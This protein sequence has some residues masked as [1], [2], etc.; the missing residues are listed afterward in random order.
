MSAILRSVLA[1]ID[2]AWA[3]N[4]VASKATLH[5]P[6]IAPI[7]ISKTSFKKCPVTR[8]SRAESPRPQQG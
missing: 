7:R 5:A 1:L 4:E 3:P 6:M 8:Q 2:S